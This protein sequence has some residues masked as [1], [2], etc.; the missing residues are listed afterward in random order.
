MLSHMMI[1][2]DTCSNE[3]T[4]DKEC[5]IPVLNYSLQCLTI[6][7]PT[8]LNLIGGRGDS[9]EKSFRECIPQEVILFI[10]SSC[11]RT[12]DQYQTL[13]AGKPETHESIKS[14]QS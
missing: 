11:I 4:T 3:N 7:V 5:L 9:P 13:D 12:C 6:C 2:F 10:H 14:W 1:A 8:S